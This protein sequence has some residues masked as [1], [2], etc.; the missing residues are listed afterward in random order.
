MEKYINFYHPLTTYTTKSFQVLQL[1]GETCW[2]SWFDSKI[3]VFTCWWNCYEYTFPENEKIKPVLKGFNAEHF[4]GI[5]NRVE[6]KRKELAIV[7]AKN[8]ENNDDISSV[9]RRS[10]LELSW[11]L[12]W[13]QK[14]PFIS[15]NP[16]SAGL[17]KVIKTPPFFI[18]CGC[19]TSKKFHYSLN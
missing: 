17:W 19:K 15:K 14:N 3:M 11:I 16:G 1:F 4:S 12:F 10:L 5:S 7:Q 6:D 2:F 18:I 8:L 9:E 13:L